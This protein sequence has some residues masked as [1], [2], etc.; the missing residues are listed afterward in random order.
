MF[1]CDSF[2]C[3]IKAIVVEVDALFAGDGSEYAKKISVIRCLIEIEVSA[4]VHILGEF[5]GA[6]AT[7][8]F[9]AC[10]YFNIL[11]LPIFVTS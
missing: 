8:F 10:I 7:D 5:S 9:D 2:D 1:D 11:N 6:S 4:I 3:P